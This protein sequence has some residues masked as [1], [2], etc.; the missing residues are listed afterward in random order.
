MHKHPARHERIGINLP[1]QSAAFD[2]LQT[3]R[4]AAQSHAGQCRRKA[5]RDR[6]RFGSEQHR[7]ADK[8]K[9][10]DHGENPVPVPK[11]EIADGDHHLTA[12]MPQKLYHLKNT[13]Q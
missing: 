8:Q 5:E 7:T 6:E 1:V 2:I 3:N 9:H 12:I 11:K 10:A 13:S 4:D